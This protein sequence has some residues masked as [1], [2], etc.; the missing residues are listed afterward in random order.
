MCSSDLRA[1]FSSGRIGP[2]VARSGSALIPTLHRHGTV[3]LFNVH[4]DGAMP[5]VM[6]LIDMKPLNYPTKFGVDPRT[7]NGQA[8]ADLAFKVPML[9]DLPVDDVGIQVKAQVSGFGVSLGRLQDLFPGWRVVRAVPNTPCLVQAGLTGLA[10]GQ[11]LSPEQQA[12]VQ[13]V[14]AQVGEVLE[15]PEVQIGR[16]HV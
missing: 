8:S 14:F 5:D 10:W 13:R 9:A 4:V 7:T 6:A 15:L 3:G 12:W 2:L 11:G 1:S 16:A